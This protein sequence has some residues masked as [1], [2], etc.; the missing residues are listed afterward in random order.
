MLIIFF[1]TT[2][3]VILDWLFGEPKRW[4]PLI[5]FGLVVKWLESLLYPKANSQNS[6]SILHGALAVLILILPLVSLSYYVA[7][8][9]V[10]GSVFSV[11][12]LTLAIGH[13]SLH[14]HAM[15]IADALLIGDDEKARHL[16]SRI[17]SR[18]PATLNIPR[19]AIESVL[20]NGA[21]SVFCALFWFVI[22]GAPAVVAY[23]LINTLDAMWG[24]RN[25][26]YLYF[27]RFAARL[28]DIVNFIPARL[29]AVT[30]AILGDTKQACH[31]WKTQ[32]KFCESPNAGPVMAAGAGALNLKLGG[33]A[34]YGGKW[35][36]RPLLGYGLDPTPKDIYRALKLVR[37]CVG[38]W[39]L[40]LLIISVIFYA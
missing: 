25:K 12:V 18:D 26:R 29:T 20:E 23:R 5:G 35:I 4:H 40:S 14:Q 19:A 21:D 7:T 6:K 10:L 22:G 24:Y 1:M 28:D 37:H 3:A 2:S 15:P 36:D 17:V 8:I 27:G 30:Y 33:P 16:T 38:V 32:A 31:A 39:L 9:P 34:Q 13:N 11:L